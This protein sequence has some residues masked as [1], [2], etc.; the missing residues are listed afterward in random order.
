[1]PTHR[2]QAR[3]APRGDWPRRLRPGAFRAEANAAVRP[4]RES[5]PARDRNDAEVLSDRQQP[6]GGLPLGDPRMA[7]EAPRRASAALAEARKAEDDTDLGFQQPANLR[8]PHRP[9]RGSYELPMQYFSNTGQWPDGP[10]TWQTTRTGPMMGHARQAPPPIASPVPRPGA[11]LSAPERP[12]VR[13][14]ALRRLQH[15]LIHRRGRGPDRT[16]SSGLPGKST[17]P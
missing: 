15:D 8:K 14:V 9:G 1:M 12:P 11:L 6:G 5:G 2:P 13:P 7:V 10:R 3:T 4:R 17:R 16:G